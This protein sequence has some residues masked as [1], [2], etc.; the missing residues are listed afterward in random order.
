MAPPCLGFMPPAGTTR[1]VKP[2]LP[3][4]GT[5]V[6]ASVSVAGRG[7]RFG[8]VHAGRELVWRDAQARKAVFGIFR[9]A[10]ALGEQPGEQVQRS[11]IGVGLGSG[12][13][14][15]VLLAGLGDPQVER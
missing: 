4:G 6:R 1:V 9:A 3:K 11:A 15:F 14:G 5:G 13:E 7:A 12:Q 8:G 2:R 10:A